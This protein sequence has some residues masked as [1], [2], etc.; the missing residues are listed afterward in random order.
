V[1]DPKMAFQIFN[2][3]IPF[4]EDWNN[5]KFADANIIHLHSSRDTT[6]RVN[7]MKD[8]ANMFNVPVDIKEEMIVL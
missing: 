8:I 4:A 3:N 6:S 1:L 5:C 7:A 2:L